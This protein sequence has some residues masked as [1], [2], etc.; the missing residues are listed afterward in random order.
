MTADENLIAKIEASYYDTLE[1]IYGAVNRE[2]YVSITKLNSVYFKFKVGDNECNLEIF[3]DYD[4]T[5][6]SDIEATLNI[7]KANGESKSYFGSM[8]YLY[9]IITQINKASSRT[10]W[11]R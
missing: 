7:Y 11:N 9:S 8:Q 1:I 5:D 2:L 4:E 3:F 10:L 6:D